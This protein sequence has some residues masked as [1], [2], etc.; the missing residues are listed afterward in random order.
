MYT[1]FT[2]VIHFTARELHSC[3]SVCEVPLIPKV[4]DRYPKSFISSGSSTGAQKAIKLSIPAPI[5]TKLRTRTKDLPG[6]VLKPMSI[7]WTYWK[8]L[9]RRAAVRS[10]HGFLHNC[11][12]QP[13]GRAQTVY[14]IVSANTK[15]QLH[16]IQQLR[17]RYR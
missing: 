9:I 5:A 4:Y 12:A 8:D 17:N 14:T 2:P 1:Q 11:Q 13:F 15:S 16:N 6:K 3:P 10:R 7:S